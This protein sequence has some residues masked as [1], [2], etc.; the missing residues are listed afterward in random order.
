M[1]K[2]TDHERKQSASEEFRSWKFGLP[3]TVIAALILGTSMAIGIG[4]LFILMVTSK[5][6]I[7]FQ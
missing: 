7:V 1:T 3:A 2:T 4:V 5:L 6:S